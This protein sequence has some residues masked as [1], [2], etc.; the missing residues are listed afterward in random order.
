MGD[1]VMEEYKRIAW[2]LIYS[3]N[4]KKLDKASEIVSEQPTIEKVIIQV[5]DLTSRAYVSQ[6]CKQH[7]MSWLEYC[8][9]TGMTTL[10]ELLADG[11]EFFGRAVWDDAE[12]LSL[13]NDLQC[14]RRVEIILI[15]KKFLSFN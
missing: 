8:I 9:R 4:I 15:N 2:G 6:D 5:E 7:E 10:E 1:R 14:A 3:N 11:V 13:I 12:Y